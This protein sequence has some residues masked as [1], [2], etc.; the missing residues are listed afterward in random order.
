MAENALTVEIVP[1][2]TAEDKRL[3]GLAL[4]AIWHVVYETILEMRGYTKGEIDE[5]MGR[6]SIDLDRA[7]NPGA[8]ALGGQEFLQAIGGEG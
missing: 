7:D 4:G 6:N 3:F 1:I 2:R 5:W 8:G